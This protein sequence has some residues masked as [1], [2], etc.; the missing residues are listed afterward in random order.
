[1]YEETLPE[2]LASRKPLTIGQI[3]VVAKRKVM[4]G[5]QKRQ[6]VVRVLLFTLTM[7]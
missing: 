7:E 1:M 4:Y 5:R 6:G 2:L 3:I